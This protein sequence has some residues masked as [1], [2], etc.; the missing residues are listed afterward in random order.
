[1]ENGSKLTVGVLALQ[2]SFREHIALLNRLPGV[3]AIE[4]RTAD[5]LASV[6]G[7]I[8]PGQ[9]TCNAATH[10]GKPPSWLI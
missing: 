7:L 5:E 8:I 1:M 3:H 4:V 6:A 10:I 9:C 2:G